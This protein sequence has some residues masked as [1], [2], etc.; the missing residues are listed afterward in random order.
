[1]LL[2]RLAE[3]E[4]SGVTRSKEANCF[5]GTRTQVK[6]ILDTLVKEEGYALLTAAHARR[7]EEY[8][9]VVFGC[10]KSGS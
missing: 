8:S 10:E 1:M 4:K 9:R 3:L 2:E 5:W 7:I 6:E